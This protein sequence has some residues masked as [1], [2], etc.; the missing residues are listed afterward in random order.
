MTRLLA[1]ARNLH[2]DRGADPVDGTGRPP[3]AAPAAAAVDQTGLSAREREVARHV[4]DG[5]TYR[6]IGTAM[7]ISPRTA[8]H[9]IGRIRRR[10]GIRTRAE[11]LTRLRLALDS[12]SPQGQ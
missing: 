9:H 1:C 2:P 10:L 4:L 7:F 8:E 3:P 11:L 12:E 6:E 5:K